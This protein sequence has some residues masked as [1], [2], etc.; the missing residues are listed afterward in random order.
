MLSFLLFVLAGTR[1][2]F[3]FNISFLLSLRVLRGVI[4][5]MICNFC[6]MDVIPISAKQAMPS[7]EREKYFLLMTAL[8]VLYGSVRVIR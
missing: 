1:V 5:F 8:I 7:S 2:C 4:L 3:F 6:G